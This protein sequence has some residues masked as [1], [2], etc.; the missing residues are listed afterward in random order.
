MRV[1]RILATTVSAVALAASFA[2]PAAAAGDVHYA[3]TFLPQISGTCSVNDF[4][5]ADASGTWRVN[6][7]EGTAVARFVIYLD[8]VKHVAYTAPMQVLDPAG[9]T[10]KVSMTTLAGEL[11]VTLTGNDLTY[12]IPS[13]DTVDDYGAAVGST[14]SGIVYHGVLTEKS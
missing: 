13:Y 2:G 11:T 3:G 7:H 5:G 9:A 14:C 4:T 10:F 1:L 6:V 12:S 8:G